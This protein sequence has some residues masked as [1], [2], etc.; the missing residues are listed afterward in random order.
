MLIKEFISETNK[1][2]MISTLLKYYKVQNVRMKHKSM[3]DHAHYVV[4]DGVLL[5]STRYKK[6]RQSQIKEFL[7]T[8]IHEIYHAMDSKKYGWKKFR[9]MWEFEANKI[10]QG[11]GAPGAKDPYGDNPHELEA[12][13]FGQ[14]HYKKWYNIFKKQDLF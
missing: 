4:E 6:L 2:Q 11:Y 8:M 5:L 13:K 7:I 9:E 3:K 10:T 14:K 12:E 1:N